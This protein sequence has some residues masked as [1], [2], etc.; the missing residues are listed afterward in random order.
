MKKAGSIIYLFLSAVLIVGGFLASTQIPVNGKMDFMSFDDPAERAHYEALR[1]HFPDRE[2]MIAVFVKNED[3]I[4]NYTTIKAADSLC[5]QLEELPDVQQVLFLTRIKFPYRTGNIER[6]RV[7]LPIRDSLKF[8]KRFHKLADYP[9]VRPKFLSA[10]N[11]ALAFYIYTSDS[12]TFTPIKQSLRDWQAEHRFSISVLGRSLSEKSYA[13][14]LQADQQKLIWITLIFLTIGFILLFRD[15]K[16][17]AYLLWVIL[18]SLALFFLLLYFLRIEINALSMSVPVLIAVMSLSDAVHV[19]E[20]ARNTTTDQLFLTLAS[21]L[22]LTTLTTVIGFAMFLLTFSGTLIEYALLSISGLMIAFVVNRYL[23]IPLLKLFSFKLSK[24]P[25]YFPKIRFKRTVPVSFVIVLGALIYLIQSHQTDHFLNEHIEPNSEEFKSKEILHQQFASDR[26]LELYFSSERSLMT[27]E[28]VHKTEKLDQLLRKELNISDS[29]G[30]HTLVKR[31]NRYLHGGNP[32]QFELPLKMDANY[33]RSVGEKEVALGLNQVISSDE[34]V[35][36]YTAGLSDQGASALYTEIE[37]IRPRIDALFG[38]NV[39]VW[40]GG[41]THVSEQGFLHL[42]EALIKSLLFAFIAITLLFLIVFRSLKLTFI[43][44]FV[45]AFPIVLTAVAILLNEQYFTA[46]NLMVLTILVGLAVDDTIH[47]LGRYRYE[48]KNGASN[49]HALK[50][51]KRFSGSAI[52]KTSV[53]LALG[54]SALLFSSFSFNVNSS[55]YFILGIFAALLADLV[56]LPQLLTTKNA[57]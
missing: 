24:R 54:L 29:Y 7:L 30:I 35:M 49:E 15:V 8:E 22:Q 5:D 44:L 41:P 14:R 13:E 43:A 9:D 34:K 47:F 6:K 20:E 11:K 33:L 38:K 28:L 42:T 50:N 19:V 25:F 52:V 12:A 21:A 45:N 16:A 56:I 37:R 46:S 55:I 48:L 51:A 4:D 36:R 18:L 31:Y 26:K 32:K 39:R 53:L 2:N 23:S 17:I 10:D 57:E 1:S 27:T 40:I 3:G